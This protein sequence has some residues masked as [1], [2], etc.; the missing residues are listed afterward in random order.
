MKM[1]CNIARVVEEK[2]VLTGEFIATKVYYLKEESSQIN[3]LSLYLKVEKEQQNIQNRQ[4]E[5][6]QLEWI[7]L[8]YRREKH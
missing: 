5:I 3:N 2:I 6:I 7:Q 1:K 4:K 8:K